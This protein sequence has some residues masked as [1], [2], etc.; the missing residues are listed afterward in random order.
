MKQKGILDEIMLVGSWCVFLYE[1]YFG[2]KGIL[3]PLRTRDLD[4]LFPLPLK[5][6]SKTD[7]FELL[8]DL[9]FILDYKGEQG[10][11]TFQHPDLILEF[12]VPANGRRKM[13]TKTTLICTILLFVVTAFAQDK[14]VNS[15]KKTKIEEAKK[16]ANNKC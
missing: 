7:L 4:F 16:E 6:K 14:N 12:L 9:G 1:D 8:K 15:E 13:K 2:R 11:I 5:L 10:Y 3:P